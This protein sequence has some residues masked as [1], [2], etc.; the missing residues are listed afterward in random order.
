MGPR[1]AWHANH[2][3]DGRIGKFADALTAEEVRRVD[4]ETS[5]Y[6]QRFGYPAAAPLR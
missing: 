3:G 4:E 1:D 5:E 6:R 2:V